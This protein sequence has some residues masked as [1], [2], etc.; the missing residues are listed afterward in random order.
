[1][2]TKSSK[3]VDDTLVEELRDTLE[4]IKKQDG[5]AAKL[6]AKDPEG[7]RTAL[8]A[9]RELL[10]ALG[11]GDWEP[12]PLERK[13]RELAENLGVGPGKV[14]QPIRVALTG[15][16]VSEPVNVLLHVVGKKSSL[17]RIEIALSNIE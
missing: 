11:D 15:E 9:A 4:E 16:T 10:E 7:F 6:I 1:M 14:F 8:G 13:L 2:T 3:R 17:E 12:E 5:K